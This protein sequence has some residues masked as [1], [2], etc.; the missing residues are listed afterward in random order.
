MTQNH[1]APLGKN[2]LLEFRKRIAAASPTPG[3]GAVAAMTASFAAALLQ[4]VC[5]ISLKRKPD[6]RI[7]TI[8]SEV[9]LCEERLAR[10]A[11]EDIL[12][13]DQYLAARKIQS[14]TAQVDAQRCLLACAEVPLAAAEAVAKLE[15][16]A[17]EMVSRTPDFL[18]SDLATAQYLLE[19]SRKALL[20]NVTAN[21]GDLEDGE[22]KHAVLLRIEA[23]Q[24][25]ANSGG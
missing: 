25:N 22:A 10:F 6:A 12:L 15:A 18:S 19:A 16:Y 24:V 23:L 3:G 2:S 17:V 21:L 13:F 7:N 8:A 4:M 20:A 1:D 14:T 11:E 9:K 5:S